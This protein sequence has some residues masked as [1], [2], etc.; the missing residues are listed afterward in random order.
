M[1]YAAFAIFVHLYTS[2]WIDDIMS[3]FRLWD[4]DIVGDQ[5]KTKITK[6]IRIL[7]IFVISNTLAALLWISLVTFVYSSL[8]ILPPRNFLLCACNFLFFVVKLTSHV[9]VLAMITHPFQILYITQHAKFQIYLFNKYVGEVCC[10]Y[11][12]ENVEEN[13]V[14]DEIYQQ[15]VRLKLK[16]QVRR[17]CDFKRYEWRI[18]TLEIVHSLIIPFSVAVGFILFMAMLSFLTTTES[19]TI[20]TC[21]NA[22]FGFLAGSGFVTMIICGE[23]LQDESDNIFTTLVMTKWY[24]FNC[25]NRKTFL[26][27]LCNSMEPINLNFSKEIAINYRLGVA[28]VFV[29]FVHLYKNKLIDDVMSILPLWEIDTAGEKIK[30][31]IQKE[32]KVIRTFTIVASFL[33]LLW[34]TIVVYS[35]FAILPPRNLVL[36][37]C[38]YL[39]SVLKLTSH[40]IIFAF[41]AHPLQVIYTSHHVKFQMYLFNKHI[42]EIC[43]MMDPEENE[44][45]YLVY[46]E[47]YQREVRRRLNFL[48]KRH[49]EFKRWRTHTLRIMDKLI[50]PFS[51]GAAVL[52]FMGIYSFLYIGESA[53]IVICSDLLFNIVAGSCIVT[54]IM[55]GEALQ[56]ESENT[57]TTLMLTK[58]Y[59]FNCENRKIFLLMLCNSVKPISINFSGEIAINYRLGMAIC[60]TVY[61]A[62]SVFL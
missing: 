1:A 7:K 56:D 53:T 4:I 10:V 54:T 8:A 26:L 42:E 21:C 47:R 19:T 43:T 12:A 62:I 45:E 27:M 37:T 6:E 41:M 13:L 25:A 39:L 31:R 23:T 61:S 14:D 5:I 3:C 60:K 49:C 52:L 35:S 15:E 28:T 40:V 32:T 58:W 11:E 44:E 22:L 16:L 24:N 9:I 33:A 36:H 20:N 17:H 2:N 38:D 51:A 55:A 46:D 18:R 48:V 30:N 50:L 34:A 57:F 29:S 59:N